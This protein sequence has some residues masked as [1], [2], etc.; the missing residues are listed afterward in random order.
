M[1]RRGELLLFVI[2]T[3]L[4][5]ALL[6]MVDIFL[7][8]DVILTVFAFVWMGFCLIVLTPTVRGD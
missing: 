7:I 6:V 2:I 4:I 3:F 5:P 1:E 8:T